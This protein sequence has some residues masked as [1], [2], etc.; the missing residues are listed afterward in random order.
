MQSLHVEYQSTLLCLLQAAQ[1]VRLSQLTCLLCRYELADVPAPKHPADLTPTLRQRLFRDAT[2]AVISA[3][4]ASATGKTPL[5]WQHLMQL[6]PAASS[7]EAQGG[8]L[9]VAA[10][11]LFLLSMAHAFR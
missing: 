2:T 1:L 6:S 4:D 8:Q 5:P 11:Q 9:T 10:A 7:A 3:L